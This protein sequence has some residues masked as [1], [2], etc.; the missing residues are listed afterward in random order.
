MFLDANNLPSIM[1]KVT[2]MPA[3][4]SQMEQWNLLYDQVAVLLGRYGKADS[5]GRGDYLI[6][7]DNY[8]WNRISVA[9]QNLHILNPEIVRN[10]QSLLTNLQEWEIVMA[11]DVP[12]TEVNWPRM[13]L[14]IR[15][16]EIIDGLQ[17]QY[18][19]DEFRSFAYPG[20]RAGTGYD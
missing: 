5:F 1:L 16:N 3:K 19:P 9:I 4:V 17:R 10:L 12:G 6:V 18:F 2:P 11:V 7:D 8:G 14:T 13:G 15:R 20:S